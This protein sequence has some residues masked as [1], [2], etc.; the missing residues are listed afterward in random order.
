VISAPPQESFPQRAPIS[1]AENHTYGQILKSSILIGGSSAL[2][3][4]IRIVRTK[5]LALLL[6]P[7]G[8]GLFGLYQS[9]MSLAQSAAGMGIN[10]SG[11]RQIAAAVGSDDARK[12]AITSHVLRRTA[13]F[14]GVMGAALLVVFSRQLSTLTFANEGHAAAISLLSLAVF[15]QLVSDGQGALIQGMRRVRDLAKMGVLGA[16]YGTL[17]SVVLVYFFRARGVVPSL[18]GAA[19]MTVVTSWWYSRKIHVLTPS[20]TLS[21]AGQEVAALLKLG[22]AFMAVTFMTM[23]IA[24]AVRI[25][26]LRKVGLE[27]AGIYQSAWTL[28]GLYAGFI[29][30]AMGADFYPRLTASANDDTTC[31]RLVNEQTRVGLLLAGPGMLATLTFAPAVIALFYSSKFAAAVGV[32]R[33]ICLGTALQVVIWPMGFIVIAKGKQ[34]I[35]VCSEVA[36]TVASIGLAWICVG[37]FGVNG[38]GMAFFGS[39]LFYVFLVYAIAHRLSGFRWSAGNKQTGLVLFPLLMVVFAGHYLLPARWVVCLGTL[40]TLLI[41][42][43]SM[44]ILLGLVSWDRIPRRLHKLLE[45]FRPLRHDRY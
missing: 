31:N 45:L 32:L 24:Y 6:G 34:A 41:G 40:A 17:I 19:G 11:V 27:A 42:V 12:V 7:T 14:L 22:F 36:W 35:F 15:F 4:A 29:L 33:W 1:T 23:G 8:Y 9:I 3:I 18:V 44:R 30:Q 13:I 10:G 21:E 26:I 43:Y 38:A 39:Y 28:G 20:V 2:N 16:I 37:H 5:A 25:I